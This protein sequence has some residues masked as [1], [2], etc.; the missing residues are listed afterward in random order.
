MDKT[1][2]C[3]EYCGTMFSTMKKDPRYLEMTESYIN[4]IALDEDK[5]IIESGCQ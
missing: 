4:R 3:K 1:R 5:E 2:N